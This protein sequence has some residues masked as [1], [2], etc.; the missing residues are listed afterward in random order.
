MNWRSSALKQLMEIPACFK[1]N[2]Q[3]ENQ[4]SNYCYLMPNGCVEDS[5]SSVAAKY[6]PIQVFNLSNPAFFIPVSVSI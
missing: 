4:V 1:N 6:A 3:S 5:R 2:Q